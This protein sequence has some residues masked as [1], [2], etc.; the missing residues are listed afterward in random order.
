MTKG[1]NGTSMLERTLR[2]EIL[3]ISPAT[4]KKLKDGECLKL[5]STFDG[6]SHNSY[7]DYLIFRNGVVVVIDVRGRDERGN[8]H[9]R[10]QEVLGVQDF[11][12]RL[13]PES[14]LQVHDRLKDYVKG[15]YDNISDG[16]Y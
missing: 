10:L 13:E 6:F 5:L 3:K 2:D 9:L 7:E 11:V 15:H 1:Q 14:L 16:F 4:L 8:S 12:R